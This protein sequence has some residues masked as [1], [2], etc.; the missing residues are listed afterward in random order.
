MD[1]TGDGNVGTREVI[2]KADTFLDQGLKALDKCQK[3][4]R[5]ADN[6]EF[7]WAT[8][9]FYESHPLAT[10]ADDEKWLEKAKKRR[11]R[12]RISVAMVVVL[13]PKGSNRKCGTGAFWL[14]SLFKGLSNTPVLAMR[15]E[16][17]E[18]TGHG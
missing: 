10:D 6:S 7:G 3:H 5:V 4:N 13:E 9:Q 18:N 8:V 12:Q 16:F 11:S 1:T 15:L 17:R 14:S 2:K